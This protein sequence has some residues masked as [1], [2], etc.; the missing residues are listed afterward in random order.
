MSLTLD[1]SNDY[2]IRDGREQVTYRSRDTRIGS[3]DTDFTI[4]DAER[5]PLTFKELAA[6][7][8]VYTGLDRAWIIPAT[9]ITAQSIVPKPADKIVDGDNTTWT[10]LNFE[11]FSLDTEYKFFCRDLVLAYQ[12][13]D[14]IQIDTPLKLTEGTT[15]INEWLPKHVDMDARI[16]LTGTEYR[17]ERGIRG[18]AKKFDIFCGDDVSDVSVDDRVVDKTGQ[19]Y[20]IRHIRNPQRIDELAVLEAEVVPG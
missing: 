3:A 14:V 5:R 11:R 12:L 17:E 13:F 7:A 6:S 18:T 9:L 20:E 19:V 15:T 8:G 16:Q 10:V 2:L 4:T 1:I